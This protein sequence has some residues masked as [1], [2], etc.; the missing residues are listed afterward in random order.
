MPVDYF[1]PLRSVQIDPSI[2]LEELAKVAHSFGEVVGLA[3]R[4]LAQCPIEL[5]L[6]P[7]SSLQRQKL[8]QKKPYFIATLCSAVL[9]AFAIGW[10]TYTVSADKRA[11]LEELNSKVAVSRK[12]RKNSPRPKPMPRNT[13]W[14]WIS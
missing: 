12:P 1:N 4:N 5:N 2:N 14:N 8:S 11:A 3:L 7:K 13:S 6:M 9:V 10:F